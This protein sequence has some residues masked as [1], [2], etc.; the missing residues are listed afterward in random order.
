MLGLHLISGQVV[1][2]EC[3]YA[4]FKEKMENEF[5]RVPFVRIDG[6]HGTRI[7]CVIAK[8]CIEMVD[9]IES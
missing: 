5:E 8:D 3:S 9:L 7:Q 1:F 2:V 6:L 4:D